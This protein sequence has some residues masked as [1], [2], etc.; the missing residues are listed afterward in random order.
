LGNRRFAG[1]IVLAAV[2]AVG[3]SGCSSIS[4]DATLGSTNGE[5][6]AIG[7]QAIGFDAAGGTAVGWTSPVSCPASFYDGFRASLPSTDTYQSVDP[8]SFT[9]LVVDPQLTKG[10]VATCIVRV[11]APQVTLTEIVF[12][13]IDQ[14]H[15]DALSKKLI[16]DG[17]VS[18]G[19]QQ[20]T[21]PEGHAITETVYANGQSHVVTGKM[22]VNST[23]AFFI[24]G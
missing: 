20:S 12:L 13:D 3:L 9:G 23:P 14:G 19:D 17:F 1:V 8:A 4:S 21:D 2:V 11:V 16:A 7:Q 24:A 5:A 15:E 6:V 10:Y 18:Q 22:T